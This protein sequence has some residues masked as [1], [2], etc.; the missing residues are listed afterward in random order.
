MK[1]APQWRVQF[2]RQLA[3]RR[4]RASISQDYL[5]DKIGVHR[6]TVMKY[7]S[8]E[9]P[10]PVEKLA[11]ICEILGSTTFVI[12]GQRIDVRRDTS[13]RKPRAVPKQ[14]RLK[15]GI[16]CASSRATFVV[17]S[18]KRGNKLDVEILSA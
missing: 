12:N 7:E 17:P 10:V 2:G 14:L 1:S 11:R 18:T 3:R 16:S 5:A 13:A 9:S 15:L 4:Q 8:G 6:Y